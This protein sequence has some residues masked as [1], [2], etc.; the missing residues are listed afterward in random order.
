MYR[1]VTDPIPPFV[2]APCRIMPSATQHRLFS[3]EADAGQRTS[4]S[5]D[6]QNLNGRWGRC[7]SSKVSGGSVSSHSP[8]APGH[9]HR[10]NSAM[11]RCARTQLLLPLHADV[12]R[13]KSR[14]FGS[15]KMTKMSNQ[16]RARGYQFQG[17]VPQPPGNLLA[18]QTRGLGPV[19]MLS[20]G[21]LQTTGM[22]WGFGHQGPGP[23]SRLF[24]CA[25][26]LRVDSSF[27]ATI[28]RETDT[29]RS[30][31]KDETFAL[32]TAEQYTRLSVDH[33]PNNFPLVAYPIPW[34]SAV[35]QHLLPPHLWFK[36]EEE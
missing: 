27:L 3:T 24:G 33:H 12:D 2:R 9:P 1:L 6:R 4:P 30:S 21:C 31:A 20:V 11:G 29:M 7:R 28:S 26:H 16:V 22:T 5:H 25:G 35:V 15:G 17:A 14:H 23:T 18:R 13:L 10:Y 34:L 19:D 32:P 8:R 36:W